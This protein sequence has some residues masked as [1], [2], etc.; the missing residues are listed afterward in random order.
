MIP[1]VFWN[2]VLIG[3]RADE[4][5]AEPSLQILRTTACSEP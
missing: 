2:D 3:S 1:N 4:Q 5:D